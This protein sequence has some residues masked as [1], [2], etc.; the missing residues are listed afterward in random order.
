MNTKEF[1]SKNNI[2][3]LYKKINKD[4]K[5][6]STK[7]EKKK[8]IDKLISNMKKVYKSLDQSKINK[9]NYKNIFEQFNKI[10]IDQLLPA[11]L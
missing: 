3:N 8:V 9:K 7:K 2:G 6:A 5:Y 4:H 11:L 10:A 1:I